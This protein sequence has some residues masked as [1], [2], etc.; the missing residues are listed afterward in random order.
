V[1]AI[2]IKE[3]FKVLTAAGVVLPFTCLRVT[4][5]NNW[6]NWIRS[7]LF[8]LSRAGAASGVATERTDALQQVAEYFRMW[9]PAIRRRGPFLEERNGILKRRI[10]GDVE[11]LWR[12]RL[13]VFVWPVIGAR[14][15][16]GD[17]WLVLRKD[18]NFRV[19]GFS[20]VFQKLIYFAFRQVVSSEIA[21]PFVK[22][23]LLFL[24][25]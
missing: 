1:P 11:K 22:L 20:L 7:W 24:S 25:R 15:G 12:G 17:S 9:S 13:A 21:G 8:F 14:G 2:P 10:P 6:R 5:Q 3:V 19:Q 18:H 23:I 4:R 16:A